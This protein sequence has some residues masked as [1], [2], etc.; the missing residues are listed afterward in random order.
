MGGLSSLLASIRHQQALNIISLLPCVCLRVFVKLWAC[1]PCCRAVA[2]LR[3]L[4][5]EDDAAGPG[6]ISAAAGPDG[7]ELYTA[8]AVESEGFKGKFNQ[9]LIRKVCI[10]LCDMF[11]TQYSKSAGT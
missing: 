5:E 3:L 1:V 8:G 9:Y 2:A 6:P 10:R 4:A 7:Q 11:C